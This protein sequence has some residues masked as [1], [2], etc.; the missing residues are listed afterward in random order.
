[1]DR[2][3]AENFR[4]TKSNQT[5]FRSTIDAGLQKKVN[6]ILKNHQ[7]R[8]KD[9][10]IHNLAAIVVDVESGNVIA[11]AGNV[12]SG[13]EHNEAVDVVKAP[14]STGSILKTIFVCDDAQ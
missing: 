9:N 14:R 13:K 1:M 5:R 10:L 6:R 4:G 11:Y 2:S 8:L 7:S 12:K 3:F